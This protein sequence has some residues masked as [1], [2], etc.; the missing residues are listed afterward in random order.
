MVTSRTT[1]FFDPTASNGETLQR[2][3]SHHLGSVGILT[4]HVSWDELVTSYL[5]RELGKKRETDHPKSN[6]SPASFEDSWPPG[7][8]QQAPDAVYVPLDSNG[9]SFR[10]LTLLPGSMNDPIECNLETRNLDFAPTYYALSYVWGK[11]KDEHVIKLNNKQFTVTSNLHSCLLHLRKPNH[12]F[13][14]WIDA[15]CIDQSNVS[16]RNHQVGQMRTIYANAYK[17]LIWLGPASRTTRRGVR[18]LRNLARDFVYEQI[19]YSSREKQGSLDQLRQR[20]KYRPIAAKDDQKS[21]PFPYDNKSWDGVMKFLHNAWFL[22]MWT[23]QEIVVGSV[24][25]VRCGSHEIEWSH[26]VAACLLIGIHNRYQGQVT[27][28]RIRRLDLC[29]Y[30][31]IVELYQVQQKYLESAEFDLQATLYDNW[32]REATDPKDKL[33]AILGLVPKLDLQVDYSLP[34]NEVYAGFAKSVIQSTH[35]L[36]ILR[37]KRW[38]ESSHDL[39]SWVP[40]WTEKESEQNFPR[41]G[42]FSAS[43]E[44]CTWPTF[45][46]PRSLLIQGVVLDAIKCVGQHAA[47]HTV[48]DENF[49]YEWECLAYGLTAIKDLRGSEMKDKGQEELIWESRERYAGGGT[50]LEAFSRTLIG[51]YLTDRVP[52]DDRVGKTYE[53][54]ISRRTLAPTYLPELADAQRLRAY[55]SQ[56]KRSVGQTVRNRCLFTTE[57]G[58]MGLCLPSAQVGDLVCVLL[59]GSVPFLLRQA[60]CG[61]TLVGELYGTYLLLSSAEDLLTAASSTWYNGWRGDKRRGT[62]RF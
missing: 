38:T 18:L 2:L 4:N 32:H 40:D 27:S 50:K 9:R 1:L 17:V 62:L 42:V 11:A 12:S 22:R 14:L 48:L 45:P 6:T 39:P 56:F 60:L 59:G 55:C 33:Y 57:T 25:T 49:L 3:K 34:I 30:H 35:N 37:A 19:S 10:L 5:S 28:D 24:A 20:S 53:V 7:D 16:E 13:R 26:L 8:V 47:K 46:T 23:L 58:Y 44:F 41:E 15:I 61:Y 36:E 51:D 43:A 21:L 31:S 29:N 52:S 54:H